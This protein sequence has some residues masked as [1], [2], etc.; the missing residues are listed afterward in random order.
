MIQRV[1]YFSHV[2]AIA[3]TEWL[4]VDDIENIDLS[5]DSFR[6]AVYDYFMT[7]PISRNSEIMAECSRR[8]LVSSSIKKMDGQ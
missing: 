4:D 2:G 5:E 6:S 7:D 3:A 1:P 8:T